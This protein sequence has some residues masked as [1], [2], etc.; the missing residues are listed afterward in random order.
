MERETKVSRPAVVVDQVSKRFRLHQNRPQ[1][2]KESLTT[3]ERVRTEEFWALRDVSLKVD[4]GSTFGLIGGNG[5]GKS[6]LLRLIA[7]IYRPTEGTVAAHGRTSPLLELGTGFH[8]ALTGRENIHLNA[9]MLGLSKRQTAER[10]GQIIEFSGLKEFV[11]SPVK[12]YSSGMY[13]RLGFAV[14]VHVDPEILLIDEVVAVGDE[15]FQ[16]RCFSHLES[17]RSQGVTTLLVSH[18]LGMMRDTCDRLLW[19]DKGQQ[20][21]IGD[22]SEV[23]KA[24][25]D[26]V[27][28]ETVV[29]SSHDPPTKVSQQL[30][31]SVLDVEFLDATGKRRAMFKTGDPLLA[32]VA[33]QASEAVEAP[34]FALEFCNDGGLLIAAPRAHVHGISSGIGHAEFFLERIPF[35]TGTYHVNAAV[36][37]TLTTELYHQRVG[38]FRLR[39]AGEPDPG[40]QGLLDVGGRWMLGGG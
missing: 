12:F 30:L 35:R 28:A 37:N 25:L 3:M 26:S 27:D 24:Y 5:S 31:I 20:A 33:Y 2:L 6:S 9:A 23:V 22:P 13:V 15:E 8:P 36:Y 29:E 10:V 21:A 4:R 1:T 39:V 7:G 17:L 14:A 34:V 38:E 16:L 11:D 18:D 32:R 19:L 40:A